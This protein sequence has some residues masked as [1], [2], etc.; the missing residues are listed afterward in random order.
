MEK[1][2]LCKLEEIPD[3]G[4]RLFRT[5]LGEILVF[6]LGGKVYGY[7]NRC[8]HLGFSLYLGTLIGSRLRCGYH[9]EVFNLETGESEGKVVKRD[10]IKKALSLERDDGEGETVYLIEG[11][12]G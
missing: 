2:R 1:E 10:L 4:L 7:D 6:R 9:G 5:H 8:P 3:G 11:A 12:T